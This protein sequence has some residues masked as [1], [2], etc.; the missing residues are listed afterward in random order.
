MVAWPPAGAGELLSV[1]PDCG[2]AGELPPPPSGV[3]A[4]KTARGEAK[5]TAAKTAATDTFKRM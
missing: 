2:L 5:V 4:R 3:P 1:P